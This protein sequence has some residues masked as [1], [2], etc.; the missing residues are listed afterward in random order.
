VGYKTQPPPAAF[1]WRI[2]A[3]VPSPNLESGGGMEYVEVPLPEVSQSNPG[4][5]GSPASFE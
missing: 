4:A 5:G 3:A 1:G 2:T